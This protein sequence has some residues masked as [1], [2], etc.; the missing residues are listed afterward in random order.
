MKFH[1]PSLQ[2][3]A[4]VASAS[5]KDRYP[6]RLVHVV[7]R[8]SGGHRYLSTCNGHVAISCEHRCEKTISVTQAGTYITENH[9]V[10]L[11][12]T[13]LPEDTII[14][15]WA[16][17]VPKRKPTKRE[18]ESDDL[19]IDEE[20]LQIWQIKDGDTN[21]EMLPDNRIPG[22]PGTST[23]SGIPRMHKL[24]VEFTPDNYTAGIFARVNGNYLGLL[25]RASE[26]LARAIKAKTIYGSDIY[27]VPS[28]EFFTD[29]PREGSPVL[30]DLTAQRW[31][32]PEAFTAWA[33][34][35]PIQRH[36]EAIRG[37]QITT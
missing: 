24:M 3:A 20:E 15:I 23:L 5:Q 6:L 9:Q 22:D 32:N 35:M 36:Q 10:P 17:S 25:S 12:D 19:W 21:L 26:I 1:L 33:Q 27:D 31:D 4:H 30:I 7:S 37:K 8:P 28:L 11:D 34:L 29:N 2:A 18:I 14:L 13:T 16:D